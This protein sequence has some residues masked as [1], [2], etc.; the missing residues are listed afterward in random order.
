MMTAS[1]DADLDDM[2]EDSLTYSPLKDAANK[3]NTPASFLTSLDKIRQSP[4]T[5]RLFALLGGNQSNIMNGESPRDMKPKRLE[6]LLNT[7]VEN[8]MET[9]K[10]SRTKEDLASELKTLRSSMLMIQR[11]CEFHRKRALAAQDEVDHLNKYIQSLEDERKSRHSPDFDPSQ[12]SVPPLPLADVSEIRELKLT[13]TSLETLNKSLSRQ[14]DL[15]R[16]RPSLS[17]NRFTRK[18]SSVQTELVEVP[19]YGDAS[20]S[21]RSAV[22]P[23]KIPLYTPPPSFTSGYMPKFTRKEICTQTETGVWA[24]VEDISER[25]LVR[26]IVS[27]GS[28]EHEN[29][30]YIPLPAPKVNPPLS[31]KPSRKSLP[32][33]FSPT[34]CLFKGI[35][36]MPTSRAE[37]LE[38]HVRVSKVSRQRERV[39]KTETTRE[40]VI[41]TRRGAS[42]GSISSARQRSDS[43]KRIWIP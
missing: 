22:S 20:P 43:S 1:M 9:K 39:R 26:R 5:A 27:I 29:H 11:D 42:T 10:A 4:S 23:F 31:D 32:T 19:D 25:P 18:D 28:G 34:E 16:S 12:I 37:R 36:T 17:G 2:L 15:L 3:E 24:T 13:I 6:D 41:G 7:P 38:P 35:S 8:P 40:E 33:D 30:Q 14:N 21:H